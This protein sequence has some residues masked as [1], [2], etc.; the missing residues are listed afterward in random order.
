M[1]QMQRTFLLLPDYL[2]DNNNKPRTPTIKKINKIKA[3]SRRTP[4]I[5]KSKTRTYNTKV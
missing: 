4:I 1:H 2:K 5:N 3:N